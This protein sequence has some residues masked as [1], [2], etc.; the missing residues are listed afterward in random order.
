MQWVLF[1]TAR[2][3][4]IHR[5]LLKRSKDSFNGLEGECSEDLLAECIE[6]NVCNITGQKF[7][8]NFFEGDKSIRSKSYESGVYYAGVNEIKYKRYKNLYVVATNRDYFRL[9]SISDIFRED[10]IKR[11]FH[12][13]HAEVALR[14]IDLLSKE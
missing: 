11:E 12:R 8:L 3:E 7:E 1:L 4:G 13:W 10:A 14:S 9:F 6:Q 5:V 2:I